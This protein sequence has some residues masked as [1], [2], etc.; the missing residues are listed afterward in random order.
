MDRHEYT[1]H[2]LESLKISPY[3]TKPK[4]VRV[5]VSVDEKLEGKIGTL[6]AFYWRSHMAKVLID[7]LLY[8]IPSNQ[9]EVVEYKREGA[10]ADV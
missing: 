4:L 5:L 9:L 8:D 10:E 2:E 7:D 3:R 6:K 1:R